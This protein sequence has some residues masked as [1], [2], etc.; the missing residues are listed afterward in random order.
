MQSLTKRDRLFHARGPATA[1]ARSPSVE[2]R[3][4]DTIR[5]D[6]DAELRRRR[7]VTSKTARIASCR[8]RGAIPY[9]DCIPER[10]VCECRCSQRVPLN[11]P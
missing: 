4:V 2:R 1:N 11:R 3:V 5:A 6:E 9:R 8:Y 10:T 7:E